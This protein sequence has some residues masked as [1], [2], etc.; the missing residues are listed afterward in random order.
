MMGNEAAG[1]IHDFDKVNLIALRR[2]ARILPGQL[3][4]VGKERSGAIP[5][6]E[7]VAELAKA[8]REERPDRGFAFQNSLGLVRQGREDQ[9]RFEG[10]VVYSPIR[11]SRSPATTL[12]CQRS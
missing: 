11:P 4:A 2:R 7:L 12:A 9:R 6:R 10:R 3:P 8:D 1:N 5:A